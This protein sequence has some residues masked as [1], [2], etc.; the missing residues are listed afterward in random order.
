MNS[1]KGEKNGSINAKKYQYAPDNL[2]MQNG[3]FMVLNRLNV[4]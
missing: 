2:R 1:S 4:F 3:F